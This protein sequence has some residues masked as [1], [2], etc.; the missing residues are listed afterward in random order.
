MAKV[1]LREK[2][3]VRRQDAETIKAILDRTAGLW[4]AR[5]IEPLGYQRGLRRQYETIR[6]KKTR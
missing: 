1:S 4:G 3:G 5:R 2:M 6:S